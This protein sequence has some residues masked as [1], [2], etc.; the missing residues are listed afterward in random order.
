M[1]IDTRGYYNRDFKYL[2][3]LPSS[4]FTT[5]FTLPLESYGTPLQLGVRIG[6]SK[7]AQAHPSCLPALAPA[8]ARMHLHGGGR[9]SATPPHAPWQRW[10]WVHMWVH[11]GIAPIHTELQPKLQP[12]LQPCRCLTRSA[13]QDA[14]GIMIM[15]SC[16]GQA[17][18]CTCA[19]ACAAVCERSSGTFAYSVTSQYAFSLRLSL[20]V[21]GEV[22]LTNTYSGLKQ[23]ESD[24]WVWGSGSMAQ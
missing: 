11:G 10:R 4:T 20:S 2:Q 16:M 22:L 6:A 23:R 9:G 21:D 18:V 7:Q 15:C 12:K 13:R 8:A 3:W 1:A 24:R 17:C 5:S 14:C 19:C